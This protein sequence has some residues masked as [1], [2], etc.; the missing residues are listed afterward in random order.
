[1][2]KITKKVSILF[3]ILCIL[4]SQGQ[5]YIS[6]EEGNDISNKV[7]FGTIDVYVKGLGNINKFIIKDSVKQS[8]APTI[9]VGDIVYFDFQ[10][11]ITNADLNQISEGDYFYAELSDYFLFNTSGGSEAVI[12][13]DDGVE[14]GRVQVVE[15]EGKKKLKVTLT[16]NAFDYTELQDGNLT[17]YGRAQK[18]GS[19]V[20]IRP[21]QSGGVEIDIE[22]GSTGPVDP[23]GNVEADGNIPEIIKSGVGNQTTGNLE[24][25]LGI[26]KDNYIEAYN[27]GTPENY[28]NVI[29]E[30]QLSSDQSVVSISA[31]LPIYIA[32]DTGRMSEAA[33]ATVNTAT[34]L[35]LTQGE[36]ESDSDFEARIRGETKVCYGVTSSNKVIIN[37]RNTPN[38]SGNSDNGMQYKN[39]LITQLT[40]ELQP[41]VDAG[42]L[43]QERMDLTI[44]NYERL[45]SDYNYG[46]FHTNIKITTSTTKA[47]GETVNNK[48]LVTW[49]GNDTGVESG[50]IQLVVQKIGGGATGVPPGTMLISKT[51]GDTNAKLQGVTFILEQKQGD[52]SYLPIGGT[53]TTDIDGEIQVDNL[54]AGTYRIKE[55]SNPNI[56]YGDTVE[57]TPIGTEENGYYYFEL[58]VGA[59]K[60]I[61]IKVK[62]Y[63]EVGVKV[64]KSWSDN[65]NQ[66]GIRPT[67]V[68]VNLLADGNV[69][70]TETLNS[71]NS[72]IKEW[73]ALPKYDNGVE[74][75]Y[76]VEEINIPTGYSPSITGSANDYT[77]TNTHV[78]GVVSK[79]VTKA[80][81]D[82]NNQ[83]GIRP[84]SI[85]VNLLANGS[86]VDAQTLNTGNNWTYTWTNLAEKSAGTAIVYTVEEVSV[87]AGYTESTTVARN[88][89]VIITNSHTPVLIN[90]ETPEQKENIVTG[91][92][93]GNSSSKAGSTSTSDYTTMSSYIL[94][95]FISVLGIT[96]AVKKKQKIHK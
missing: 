58:V 57:Y 24:W 29:V 43:S 75:S 22:K 14:I 56:G 62:N 27:N 5:S 11:N 41:K 74:I 95:C 81:N 48:A 28:E 26:F 16:Q 92:R 86:V 64:T 17:A 85:Q 79:K 42:R 66:D 70:D 71:G 20:E 96:I 52:G 61:E 80:W 73:T 49:D 84:S 30:D 67:S 55:T 10:W 53:Y 15:H 59:T 31:T 50:D 7:N 35:K 40:A 18:E 94:L 44:Q 34:L 82:N 8:D 39:N 6:A 37:L 78:P 65:N 21:G 83:D 25:T 46:A 33:A 12:N 88:G 91:T 2:K 36:S 32:T 63:E 69:I 54:V 72:W 3:A 38:T 87:P 89:D 51:N 45:L 1:M 23:I 13:S 68:E 60:G 77:I 4:F 9:K 90:N 19:D 47:N 76:T 93:G